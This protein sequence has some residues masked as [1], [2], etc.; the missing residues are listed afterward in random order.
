MQDTLAKQPSSHNC[1]PPVPHQAVT[2]K[3]SR[4]LL[5]NSVPSYQ[6]LNTQ[7]Y[8]DDPLDQEKDFIIAAL[9]NNPGYYSASGEA[10]IKRGARQAKKAGQTSKSSLQTQKKMYDQSNNSQQNSNQKNKKDNWMMTQS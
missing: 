2:E 8:P 7:V 6:P 1:R 4:D 10:N 9:D 3:M 5:T